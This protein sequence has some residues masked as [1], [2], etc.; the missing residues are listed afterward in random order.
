MPTGTV[1]EIPPLEK[2]KICIVDKP[3]AAQSV[4]VVGDLAMPRNSP[5]FMAASL[6]THILGAGSTERL[7]MNL[8]QD[9]GYTYGAY[10][11]LTGR[12]GQGSMVAY[13]QVQTE[14]TD[15]AVYEF[16]KE[17][18]DISATR[19]PSAEELKT[20]KEF[21]TRSF[22]QAFQTLNDVADALADIIQYNRPENSWLTYIDRV[23]ETN[24]DAIVA[25][26]QKY[27]RADGLLI[28][29]VGDRAKIEQG[30]RDLNWGMLRF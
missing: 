4:I 3:G 29:V 22:P 23:T 1:K 16:V 17:I 24:A 19:P 15:K 20:G 8:R 9:K 13:A 27:L 12:K 6:A 2:T 21:L 7:Y 25:A 26:A 28:V 18:R 30:L 11:F 10:S 14:V 5:E